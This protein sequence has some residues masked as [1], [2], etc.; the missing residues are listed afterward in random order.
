VLEDKELICGS[1]W[2]VWLGN[3]AFG[4]PARL[5]RVTTDAAIECW[6][7]EADNGGPLLKQ[8]IE[9]LKRQGIDPVKH[10]RTFQ[11]RGETQP[12]NG[13]RVPPIHWTGMAYKQ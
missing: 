8:K 3:G 2:L 4:V 13:V 7:W 6:I 9:A 1:R 5:E 12:T 10:W 11:T